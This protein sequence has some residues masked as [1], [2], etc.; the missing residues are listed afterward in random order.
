MKKLRNFLTFLLLL[1]ALLLVN[2]TSVQANTEKIADSVSEFSATQGQDNWYYGYAEDQLLAPFKE[3]K[4]YNSQASIWQKKRL[5][6]P[7]IC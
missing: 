6:N 2:Q 1:C 7:S 5:S 3:I 4:D